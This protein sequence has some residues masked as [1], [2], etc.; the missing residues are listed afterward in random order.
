MI[1][2]FLRDSYL[3]W[4]QINLRRGE[5]R[6]TVQERQGIRLIRQPRPPIAVFSSSHVLDDVFR[7]SDREQERCD[8]YLPLAGAEEDAHE[9]GVR[10]GNHNALAEFGVTHALTGLEQERWFNTHEILG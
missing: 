3:M 2:L 8:G 6:S 4:E 9:T 5:G 1:N 10:W 7:A